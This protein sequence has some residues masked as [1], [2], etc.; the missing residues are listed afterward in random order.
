M[1]TTRLAVLAVLLLAARSVAA[2]DLPVSYTVSEKPLK[3]AIASTALTFELYGDAAC[4]ALVQSTPVAIENVGI[5]SK[6]KRMTPKGDV[7]LPNTVELRTTLTGVTAGGNLYLKVVGTGVTPVGGACQAQAAAVARSVRDANGAFV[8]SFPDYRRTIGADI[9]YLP[10]DNSGIYPTDPLNLYFT[11]GDCTGTPLLFA[12]QGF[13]K[14]G[15]RQPQ[16]PLVYIPPSSAPIVSL[17]SYSQY[18]PLIMSPGDC[19]GGTFVA[20]GECC[21]PFAGGGNFGPA[22]TFDSS[23]FALPFHVEGQQ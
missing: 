16:S 8:A 23:V 2:A 6:L 21:F 7:K 5:L 1:P 22:T 13:V 9:V 19:S 18:T 3:A 20:M 15:Y 11:S 14:N 17:G 4:A 12:S 10:L